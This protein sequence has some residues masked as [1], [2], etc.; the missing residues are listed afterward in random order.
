MFIDEARIWVK[1]GDGGNGAVS[2]HTAKY[3]PNGGPDGGNGGRGGSVRVIADRNISTLQA[4]RFQ[5]KYAAE[6]GQNGMAKKMAGRKGQDVLIQVPVGT[7]LREAESGRLLA[8]LTEDGQ[9]VL[10]SEGGRGG[11]GNMVFATSTRQAPR[12]AKPGQR[13][14]GFYVNLELKLLADVGLIGLPNVGKSTYLS[15]VSQAKPKIADYPFTTLEPQLGIATVG[16]FSFTIA[17]I[18]G[19]IEGASQGAGLGIDFLRHIERTRLLVHFLD[20]SGSEGRDPYG[21][22]GLINKEL[23]EFDAQLA[24]RPQIVALNKIDMADPEKLAALKAR[25]EGEGYEVYELSAPIHIG[26]SELLEAIARKLATL[27]PVILNEM[28]ET[29]VKVYKLEADAF[30]VRRIDGGFSVQGPWIDEL[31][32]SINFTDTESLQYFQKQLRQ[33]GVIDE[34]E[35]AGVQEGDEIEMGDLVFDYIF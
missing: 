23:E 8:D 4:F 34:L 19:L 6:D 20:A 17:D 26:T 21:D 32:R 27:P 14:A 24:A 30:T 3:V 25:I 9:E 16:D 35:K 10:L 29:E 15:I 2:F 22:F 11:V 18:P 31:M 1:A 33:K 7:I 12:F 28:P 13:V 5:R